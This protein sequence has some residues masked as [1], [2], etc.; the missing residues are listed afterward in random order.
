MEE[1]RA[2]ETL[3]RIRAHCDDGLRYYTWALRRMPSIPE[4]AG[5]VPNVENLRSALA[6]VLAYVEGA[7][8]ERSVMLASREIVARYE[9][10]VEEDGWEPPFRAR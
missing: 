1:T 10:A 4:Q 9:R 8:D 2:A 6:H 7:S 5:Q 3:V